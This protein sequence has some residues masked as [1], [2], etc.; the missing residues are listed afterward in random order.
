[1]LP[2]RTIAVVAG[3]PVPLMLIADTCTWERHTLAQYHNSVCSY[4]LPQEVTLGTYQTQNV[5]MQ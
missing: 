3:G 2:A 5:K 4:K 1:M